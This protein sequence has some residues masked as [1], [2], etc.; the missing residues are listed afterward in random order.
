MRL[1]NLP[2]AEQK[3]EMSGR[4]KVQRHLARGAMPCN[5]FS[6]GSMK[7]P[8]CEI[9]WN[10][11]GRIR[12]MNRQ[13]KTKTWRCVNMEAGRWQKIKNSGGRDTFQTP[14]SI[15]SR[16]C[17]LHPCVAVPLLHWIRGGGCRGSSR[18]HGWT[19]RGQISLNEGT[20][21]AVITSKGRD[22]SSHR[23]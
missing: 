7:L 15:V 4:R 12:R 6:A 20:F 13:Q 2:S 9:K 21:L 19:P 14:P 18:A 17:R 3:W 10:L 1:R 23:G 22:W 8:H 11:A 5:C 16:C